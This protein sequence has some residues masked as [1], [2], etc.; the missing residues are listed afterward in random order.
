MGNGAAANVSERIVVGSVDMSRTGGKMR[1][2]TVTSSFLVRRV[3]LKARRTFL[4]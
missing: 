4:P 2:V 3:G 1:P